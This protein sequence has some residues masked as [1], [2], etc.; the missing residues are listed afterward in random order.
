[1]LDTQ[2]VNLLPFIV[3]ETQ[4]KY[5]DLIKK[6]YVNQRYVR[7]YKSNKKETTLSWLYEQI[8]LQEHAIGTAPIYQQLEG[9]RQIVTLRQYDAAI[10]VS[11]LDYTADD[12]GQV[13]EKISDLAQV[14]ASWD[15]DQFISLLENGTVGSFT[16][17]GQ[18]L[19]S[20]MHNR[21][22][23]IFD[24][25]LGGLSINGAGLAAVRLAMA[26][27]P[28]DT[29]T[30]RAMGILPTDIVVP[31]GLWQQAM[32]YLGNTWSPD[33]NRYTENV[34]QG[35][36]TVFEIPQL[37]DQDDWYVLHTGNLSVEKPLCVVLHSEF[38]DFIGPQPETS[39]SDAAVRDYS[40][41]RWWVRTWRAMVPGDPRLFIKV[42]N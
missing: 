19:F 11:I 13:K 14:I 33:S 20:N 16:F 31:T 18:P 28:D 36:M 41:Y 17:D 32:E 21:N 10:R 30:G 8:R 9:D 23:A 35:T 1:M 27:F 4:L 12:F 34:Y 40:E 5:R 3:A 2:I 37:A 24:N 29:G 38:G 15:Y 26:T 25:L 7:Q 22:G 42:V 6:S 39:M